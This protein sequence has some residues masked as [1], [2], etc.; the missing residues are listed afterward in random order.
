LDFCCFLPL[1]IK[2]KYGHVGILALNDLKP[3]IQPIVV[4]VYFVAR[5][6]DRAI[7]ANHR[8]NIN[9]SHLIM[10]V[11]QTSPSL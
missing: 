2:Q 9:F 10:V 1:G 11:V 4:M 7:A 8:F 3:S 5:H 6:V